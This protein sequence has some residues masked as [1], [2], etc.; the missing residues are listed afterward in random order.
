MVQP[1]AR[2]HAGMVAPK[3]Q[4]YQTELL[5]LFVMKKFILFLFSNFSIL[6]LLAQLNRAPAYPLIVH[7]PYFSI[8][9][10]TDQLNGSPTK[11]WT[12]K[13]HPLL[14]LIKVDGI[15][16]NFLGLPENPADVI[17]PT[18]QHK[19]YVC[20]YTNVNPGD[21]W[22][23]ENYDDQTWLTG[24]APF[25]TRNSNPATIWSSQQIWMRRTFNL[26][27]LKIERLILQIRHDDD[28]EVYINGEKAYSCSPCWTAGYENYRL[29]DSIKKK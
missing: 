15:M 9:S 14:G 5:I 20:K 10:F 1:P 19:P 3:N 25:G 21:S 27:D 18:G 22:M 17:L 6:F 23:K 2:S 28:V 24:K 16:Y 13:N 7:D 11:H 4:E 29:D 26:A 8:W 12:G